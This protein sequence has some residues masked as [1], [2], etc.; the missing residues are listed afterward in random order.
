MPTLNQI[1]SWLQEKR[2]FTLHKP[3]RKK[4]I[5]KKVIVGGAN[6]QLQIDLID[7]QKWASTNDKYR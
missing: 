2:A 7:M 1:K 6:I 5:M 4:Y 3:A